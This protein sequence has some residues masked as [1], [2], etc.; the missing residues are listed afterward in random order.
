LPATK[1]MLNLPPLSVAPNPAGGCERNT[2]HEATVSSI[3]ALLSDREG[4]PDAVAKSASHANR[5]RVAW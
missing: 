1:W 5:L 2:P 4:H 3:A